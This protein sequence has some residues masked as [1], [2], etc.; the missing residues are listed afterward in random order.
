MTARL[1]PEIPEEIDPDKLSLAL[2][3]EAAA[4]YCQ[5]MTQQELA[6]YA[7]ATHP[8][9][10]SAYMVVDIGGG[11]VDISAHQVSSSPDHH[12]K[13]INTPAGNDCGGSV[14]NKNFLKFLETL[15][16]DKDFS[17]YIA[18]SDES[19]NASNAAYLNELGNTIFEKQKKLF[20]KKEE[21][22]SKVSVRLHLSFMEVYKARLEKGIQGLKDSRIELSGVDL[23]I[24]Y[25]KMEEFF[26]PVIG[27]ILQCIAEAMEDLEERITMVYL[28]GG[29]GGCPYLYNA[30]TEHFG[31]K[32]TYVTPAESDFAV[33][34]GAVLFCQNPDI[35]RARKAD[36]TY[37]V[38]ANIPF[39]EGI[40]EENYKWHDE[41]GTPMCQ[42]I[43]STFVERGD[44][45]NT[46]EIFLKSY[47]PANSKQ[48]RM[49]IDIYSSSETDVWYITGIRPKGSSGDLVDVQK[50]GE[51][52]VPFQNDQG[53]QGDDTEP[54][55][56]R[57]IDVTFDFSHTEIQAKGYDPISMNEVKV[58]LD[59]LSA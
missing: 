15:V 48:K 42:N 29:F 57:N 51:V 20:A 10:S 26:K 9:T 17:E 8:Y 18:T 54:K 16:G 21:P 23:R 44:I 36:A 24:E 13:V 50:V 38:R 31:D 30:I 45:L 3:P 53:A 5:S 2:E 14:V 34:R 27:G 6:Q 58:V 1:V 22:G 56:E 4:I 41:N 28:V 33:V 55:A 11:T 40:H 52:I 19:A 39:E 35:V 59:F 37:G 46:S 47:A 7:K 43:F 49:H 12:M 32:Y 25:S